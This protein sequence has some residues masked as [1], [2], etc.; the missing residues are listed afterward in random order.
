MSFAY[1]SWRDPIYLNWGIDQSR[2]LPDRLASW[3]C[4]LWRDGEGLD[5]F[6]EAD[7]LAAIPYRPST[8]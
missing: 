8:A 7:G 1:T 3:E 4:R 6:G 2:C 5:E